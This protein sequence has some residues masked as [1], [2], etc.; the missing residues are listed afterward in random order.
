M[1][2][3]LR[4][5]HEE[6]GL[7][8]SAERLRGR[9]FAGIADPGRV[10][11]LFR[12]RLTAPEIAAIRFGHEGQAWRMMPVAAFIAHPR[13]VPHFRDRVRLV[14]AAAGRRA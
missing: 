2:C 6:F 14:L 5:L 10:S 7:R 1:A 8:L 3:A 9:A 12:G 4:E 13:V 11:W